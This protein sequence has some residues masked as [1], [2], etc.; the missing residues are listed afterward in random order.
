MTLLFFAE[1]ISNTPPILSATRLISAHC[2]FDSLQNLMASSFDQTV[3]LNLFRLLEAEE[4]TIEA[5]FQRCRFKLVKFFAWRRCED[6]E[7]LADETISRLLKKVSEGKEISAGNP[8]SYVYAIA[9]NVFQEY[10][11]AKEKGKTLVNLDELPEISI[12]RAIDD[13][14]KQCFEQLSEAKREL[15]AHY[16]LDHNDRNSIAQE[17]SLSLNALRLKVHRIKLELKRCC[18]D[19]RKRSESGEINFRSPHI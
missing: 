7:S 5:R 12:S 17:E 1:L 9:S 3:F 10:G 4:Q 2:E 8:Y 18:E 16:Y 6:P 13:C 11:R 15:L 14:Q 19:C